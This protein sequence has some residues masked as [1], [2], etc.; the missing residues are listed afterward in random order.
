MKFM[1]GKMNMEPWEG[2]RTAKGPSGGRYFF[3]EALASGSVSQAERALEEMR[4]RGWEEAALREGGWETLRAALG[5]G[6]AG[7]ALLFLSE[8]G[9]R[10]SFEAA[11]EALMASLT[12]GVDAEAIEALVTRFGAGARADGSPQTRRLA[13]LGKGLAERAA[14]QFERWELSRVAG[15][16]KARAR[17][18]G[19]I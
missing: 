3:R 2:V 4:G 7:P 14:A 5:G 17:R 19:W 9:M 15:E 10:I 6:S 16:P 13:E 12:Q 1:G 18:E 8:R 11:S